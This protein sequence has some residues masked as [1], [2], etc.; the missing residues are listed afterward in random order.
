MFEQTQTL[1]KSLVKNKIN[2][3]RREEEDGQGVYVVPCKDCN[4]VYVGETGRGFAIRKQEH[5]NACRMG[6][7][8]NAIVSH[9]LH[10]G[11]RIDFDKAA[12]ISK[13]SNIRTRRVIEGALIHQ[14]DTF[15][16]NK[17]FST[18]DDL[19]SLYV[20][21]AAPILHHKLLQS[22]PSIPKFLLPKHLR[23]TMEPPLPPLQQPAPE[24]HPPDPPLRRS[25]RI[26]A[27]FRNS[28]AD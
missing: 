16:G 9:T 17:S 21:K 6:Y 1:R 7:T 8:N 14:L 10:D 2:D 23:D 20:F 4:S 11:H 15:P 12:L 13:T 3:S 28:Q 24:D 25:V 26:A 27:R 5:I 18:D 22:V 19:T